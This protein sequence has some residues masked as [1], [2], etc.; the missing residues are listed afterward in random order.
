[1]TWWL[2]GP[3]PLVMLLAW[4]GRVTRISGSSIELLCM[5][6]GWLHY[7]M[8]DSHVKLE[9]GG[10]WWNAWKDKVNQNSIIIMMYGLEF[11]VAN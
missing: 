1:M 4:L 9:E 11:T 10:T 6:G 8:E 3:K 5:A 2:W 7:V